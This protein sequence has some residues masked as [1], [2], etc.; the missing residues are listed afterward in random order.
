MEMRDPNFFSQKNLNSEFN[1]RFLIQ[2]I[3]HIKQGE[4][5]EDLIFPDTGL[6]R[7]LR[8]NKEYW[9][10]PP[11]KRHLQFTGQKVDSFGRFL[12]DPC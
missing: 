11:L 6:Q 2:H 5:N 10:K 3:S 7:T 12:V 1:S 9:P 8:S 4:C